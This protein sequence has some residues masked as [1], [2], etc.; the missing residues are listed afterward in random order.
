VAWQ[1]TSAGAFEG[2]LPGIPVESQKIR[3]LVDPIDTPERKG[4]GRRR[5]TARQHRKNHR[6][7][8]QHH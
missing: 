3:H 6:A 4:C 5:M 8:T 7:K 2:D 1:K